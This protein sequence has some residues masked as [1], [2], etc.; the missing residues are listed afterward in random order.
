[1]YPEQIDF[2]LQKY[3]KEV[4]AE[5]RKAVLLEVLPEKVYW[6][7]KAE[8]WQEEAERAVSEVH[9]L[10]IG[11]GISIGL[12]FIQGCLFFCYIIDN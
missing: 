5:T 4:A 1:M 3:G 9:R 8:D 12:N 10:Q 7:S 2:V 6:K 11:L